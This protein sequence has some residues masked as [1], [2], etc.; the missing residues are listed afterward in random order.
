ML[1][2]GAWVATLGAGQPANMFVMEMMGSQPL[3]EACYA[4]LLMHYHLLFCGHVC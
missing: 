1:P 4:W 3:H 2:P